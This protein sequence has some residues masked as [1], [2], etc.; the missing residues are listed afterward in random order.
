MEAVGVCGEY[1]NVFGRRKEIG[2]QLMVS[3]RGYR[4]GN[5]SCRTVWELISCDSSSED[6][7]ASI[8]FTDSCDQKEA[9]SA[10]RDTLSVFP[11]RLDV[12]VARLS[13]SLILISTEIF[14]GLM[15]K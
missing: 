7:F 3:A 10:V 12:E 4:G 15:F 2:G 11:L 14:V 9:L 5:E 13:S 6:E 8:S 1:C